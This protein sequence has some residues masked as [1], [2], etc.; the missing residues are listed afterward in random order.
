MIEVIQH[1]IGNLTFFLKDNNIVCK[2][3]PFAH[4]SLFLC[5][6]VVYAVFKS[7]ELLER[8]LINRR[9]NSFRRIFFKDFDFI[10]ERFILTPQC[11]HVAVLYR[12]GAEFVYKALVLEFVL[13]FLG[14]ERVDLL[15][16]VM[17]TLA[18]CALLAFGRQFLFLPFR[19]CIFDFLGFFPQCFYFL[20]QGRL[21][22]FKF[23]LHARVRVFVNLR[24]ITLH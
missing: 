10:P 21:A 1:H 17:H 11:I 20:T 22:V 4:K 23:Y 14:I 6:K 5:C 19:T 15:F 13:L 12:Q 2:D 18:Q 16:K 9:H 24:Q 8:F 7:V 3:I